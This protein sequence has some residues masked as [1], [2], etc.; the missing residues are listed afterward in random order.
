[1]SAPPDPKVDPTRVEEPIEFVDGYTSDHDGTWTFDFRDARGVDREIVLEVGG[2]AVIFRCGEL[3][4][5]LPMF[6]K[7]ERALLGL[8]EHWVEL[9][10]TAKRWFRRSE[11]WGARSPPE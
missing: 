11:G 8:L 1:M 2:S 7:E 6:S 9:D 5:E 10:P 3:S 4:R